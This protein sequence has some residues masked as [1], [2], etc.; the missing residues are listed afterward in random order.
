VV[1]FRRS[2]TDR[3]VRSRQTAHPAIVSIDTFTQAQLLR[4][5]K[6]AGGLRT[7]CKEERSGRGTVRPYPLRGRLRCSVCNRKMEASPR[8]HGTYYRCPA[9]T[10]A[11]NSP[12]LAQ[13]PAAVYV[14]E[15]AICAPLNR[16]IVTLFDTQNRT[17]TI[18]TLVES[19]GGSLADAQREHARRRLTNAGTKL[20][21]HQAA[22]EA[23]IDPAAL[24]DAINQAQAERVAAHTELNAQP[25]ALELTRQDIE[26]MIDSIGDI[27]ATI[28]EAEPQRLTAL[29]DAL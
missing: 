21:R 6:S 2:S 13:H 7:T 25:A 28:T 9:R 15:A 12:I 5:S 8:A 23:G 4:R 17:R 3:V 26:T 1:R 24:I 18:Q 16:W 22:I 27:I 29:Y 19:Q 14:R 10:L 20:R 11:P